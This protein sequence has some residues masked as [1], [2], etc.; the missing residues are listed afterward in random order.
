MSKERKEEIINEAMRRIGTKI[1][2][3]LDGMTLSIDDI[4]YNIY[5][6]GGEIEVEEI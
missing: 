6:D 3:V 4:C 1:V 2:S 5:V